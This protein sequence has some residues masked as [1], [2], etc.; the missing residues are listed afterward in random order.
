MF[1]VIFN[2]RFNV[3]MYVICV[4]SVFCIYRRM[5]K[6]SYCLALQSHISQADCS[7]RSISDILGSKCIL[8][9]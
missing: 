8:L 3:P 7:H 1:V 9:G 4:F 5:V 2:C 6:Q